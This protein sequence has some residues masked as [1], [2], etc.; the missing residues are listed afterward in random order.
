MPS[1]DNSQARVVVSKDGPY[2]VTGS[3]PLAVSVIGVDAAGESRSWQE[4]RALP[5]LA[6]YALCRCGGSRNKP[7][8]DGTHLKRGFDGAE[9]ASHRPSAERAKVFD[10]PVLWMTDDE[11]LCAFARF[12]DPNG[13]VWT[14]VVRTQDPEASDMFVRQVNDCPSGRLVAWDKSTGA[15]IEAALTPSIGL[16]EDP[17]KAC[18]G[19]LA[20]R[21]AITVVS[22]EG[23]EYEA[24]NRVTLCRCGRSA[25]KPFCDGSHVSATLDAAGPAA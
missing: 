22:T 9:T 1:Q 14:Q 24:R 6:A 15:A 10:G 11:S 17:L 8:C 25:N 16:V 13:Q 4:A 2:L 21:G 23:V 7:F 5:P 19:P 3:V 12:C 20:L 18:S